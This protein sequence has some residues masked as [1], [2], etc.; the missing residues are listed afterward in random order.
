MTRDK[1]AG[2]DWGLCRQT[3]DLL[4]TLTRLGLKFSCPLEKVVRLKIDTDALKDVTTE[5]YR[6]K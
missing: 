6:R 5:V 1:Y 4:C 2:R 3:F